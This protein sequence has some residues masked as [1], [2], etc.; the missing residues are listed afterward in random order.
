MNSVVLYSEKGNAKLTIRFP[1]CFDI[2][3]V[4]EKEIRI[5]NTTEWKVRNYGELQ[6]NVNVVQ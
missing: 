5:W 1:N 3:R 6:A 2:D 4:V